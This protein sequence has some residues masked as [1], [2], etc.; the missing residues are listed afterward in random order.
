MSLV[1]QGSSGAELVQPLLSRPLAERR[2]LEPSTTAACLSAIDR[3]F[4]FMV[5]R[6]SSGWHR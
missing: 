5:E 4:S 3:R 1:V 2:I 6:P